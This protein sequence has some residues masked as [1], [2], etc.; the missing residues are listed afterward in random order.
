MTAQH[1]FV[2][3]PALRLQ[4]IHLVEPERHYKAVSNIEDHRKRNT[5]NTN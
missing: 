3:Q 1:R 2:R 5:V 4:N